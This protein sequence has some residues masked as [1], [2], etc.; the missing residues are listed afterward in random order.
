MRTL[1]LT[2]LGFCLLAAIRP[3]AAQQITSP[4]RFIETS[5]SVGAYLGY[6]WAGSVD[7][8]AGPQSAPLFGVQYHGRLNGG[9]LGEA[10]L[11]FAPSRRT[12]FA[13][14]PDPE[15]P[16]RLVPVAQEEVG[17]PLLLAEG[18]LRFHITGPRTWNGLAPFVLGGIGVALNLAGSDPLEE[19]AAAADRF[20]FG[21]ALAVGVGLGTDYFLSDR[22]SLN[23][24]VRDR[25]WR[26][27]VPPGLS[28][29]G[30]EESNWKNNPSISIGAAVHF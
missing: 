7:P 14:Q 18:A 16:S 28:D 27:V 8:D 13:N 19:D 6:L 26:I 30:L 10:M 25:L 17:A 23:L 2:W 5:H 4:Y 3:A 15:D 11:S 12:I 20:D 9:L 29:T 22:L 24:E 21:P 1:C